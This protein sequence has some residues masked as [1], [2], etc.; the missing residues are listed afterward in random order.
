[1]GRMVEYRS[2]TVAL[3]RDLERLRPKKDVRVVWMIVVGNNIRVADKID[4]RCMNHSN[5][6]AAKIKLLINQSVQ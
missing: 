2:R 1:M 4:E 6:I 5:R 3:L